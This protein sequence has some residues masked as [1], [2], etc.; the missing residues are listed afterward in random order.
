M[1]LIDL[2]QMYYK[3]GTNF[4]II[5]LT[6]ICLFFAGFSINTQ[7]KFSTK[8][9]DVN[10]EASVPNF[11]PVGAK[12]NTVSAILKENGDF[13][14][15]ILIKGFKFEVVRRQRNQITLLRITPAKQEKPTEEE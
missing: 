8:S 7:A 6:C 2:S 10:F 13:A 5:S 4:Y 3:R 12:N 11:E 1:K 15:L 9:G 14:A